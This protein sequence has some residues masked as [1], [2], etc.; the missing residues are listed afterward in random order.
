VEGYDTINPEVV[1][2]PVDELLSGSYFWLIP[3]SFLYTYPKKDIS[4]SVLDILKVKRVTVNMEDKNLLLSLEEYVP[5]ALW[6]KETNCWLIDADGTAFVKAPLLEGNTLTRYVDQNSTPTMKASFADLEVMNTIQG[7]QKYFDLEY[8]WSI[9]RV[10][11]NREDI[12]YY[13]RGD[14]YI[15]TSLRHGFASSIK[16]LQTILESN[17]FSHL[18]PGNFEYIDLRYQSRVFVKEQFAEQESEVESE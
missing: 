8:N 14:S 3:K 13:L 11:K 2:A 5:F 9:E 12:F 16:N 15:K 1:M 17:D 4:H 7:W 18:S 6:C 10:E